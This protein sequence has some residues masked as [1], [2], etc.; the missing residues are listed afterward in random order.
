M[1]SL[2]VSLGIGL[3]VFIGGAGSTI[4]GA[5]QASS[6]KGETLKLNC[7]F[8]PSKDDKA[9]NDQCGFE[10]SGKLG[11]DRFSMPKQLTLTWSDGVRTRIT[12]LGEDFVKPNIYIGIAKVDNSYASFI[13]AGDG[14][15]CLKILANE[16]SIC[17]R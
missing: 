8:I 14:G 16:N 9:V 5:P 11:N 10:S 3:C 6:A 2:V 15:V 7:R 12:F 1:K 13:K 4:A 17:Y